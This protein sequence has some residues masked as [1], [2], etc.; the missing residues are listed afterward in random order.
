[1][2]TYQTDGCS[3]RYDR[4]S[5]ITASWLTSGSGFLLLCLLFSDFPAGLPKELRS[6]RTPGSM[7]LSI[8][9]P[10]EN[11]KC[12]GLATLQKKEVLPETP[13]REKC[14]IAKPY[15]DKK[16]HLAVKEK[17]AA[18]PVKNLFDNSKTMPEKNFSDI[19][20]AKASPGPETSIASQTQAPTAAREK[21]ADQFLSA[22]AI[23]DSL[24]S[25][26][27]REKFYPLPAIRAGFEGKVTFLVRIGEDGNITECR[28]L[29]TEACGILLDAAEKTMEKV[30]GSAAPFELAAAGTEIE[31]PVVFRLE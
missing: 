20:P 26:V 12:P 9:G 4:T 30:V 15:P 17:I 6:D 16:K 21:K 14:E 13:S 10:H 24:A 25:M 19:H 18:R 1:M 23:A 29:K 7:R 5:R 31:V 28:V 22:S 3:C 8:S 11:A 2:I 27:D